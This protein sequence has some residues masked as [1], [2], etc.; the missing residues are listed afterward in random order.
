[1][2]AYFPLDVAFLVSIWLETLM[3]GI[4]LP[5]F[6]IS[7]CAL[8]YNKKWMIPVNLPMVLFVLLMFAL[9]TAHVGI[10]TWRM[11]QAYVYNS[12]VSGGSVAFL[13]SLAQ[14]TQSA[15]DAIYVT[16]T[17]LGDIFNIYRSWLVW[18]RNYWVPVFPLALWVATTVVGYYMTTSLFPSARMD[19]NAFTEL[20]K[21]WITIW[22]CLSVAQNLI[23]TTLIAFRLWHHERQIA[24]YRKSGFSLLP[25]MLII[26]ES[27]AIYL[28]AQLLAL[29][30]LLV[31]DNAS[32]TMLELLT[33]LIGIV[34]CQVII[35]TSLYS[36]QARNDSPLPT[37]VHVSAVTDTSK[38]LSSSSV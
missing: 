36:R 33:P 32:F 28:A 3:Y 24:A 29:I 15:K 6:V 27:A 19:D 38:A 25:I 1:M 21:T 11:I 34:F 30:L 14:P 7:I 26:V 13:L 2:V 37:N 8:W 22:Y 12:S 17:L 10:N 16:Q 23:T 5:T 4:F 18:N 31:N 9:A 20:Y 35:R